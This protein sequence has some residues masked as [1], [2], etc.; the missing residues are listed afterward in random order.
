MHI[1]S[2]LPSQLFAKLPAGCDKDFFGLPHWYEYLPMEYK[3]GVCSIQPGFRLLGDGTDSGLL[4]IA[5]AIIEIALRLAGLVAVGFVLWGGFNFLTSQG[6]AENAARARHT[7]FNA[8][9]GLGIVIVSTSLV[10]FV[11]QT[12]SKG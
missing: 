7:I 4:L 3:D 12:L 9:I 8:L 2:S 11:G 10:V 5:L 1:F 6:E